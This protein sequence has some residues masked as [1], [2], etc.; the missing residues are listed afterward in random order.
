MTA[1]TADGVEVK[2]G[3]TVWC[4]S[5]EPVTEVRVLPGQIWADPGHH[6]VSHCCYSSRLAA[7]TAARA[8]AVAEVDRLDG[9]IAM[10]Q[11]LT[12]QLREEGQS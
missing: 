6:L 1:R 4:G 3:D 2:A 11:M 12:G 8:R 5:V 7:L 9:E 10:E